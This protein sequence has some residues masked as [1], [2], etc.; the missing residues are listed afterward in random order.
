MRTFVI[1]AGILFSAGLS[2]CTAPIEKVSAQEGT[3][4]IG[5]PF[6]VVELFTSEGCTSCPKA[7]ALMPKMKEKYKDQVFILEYHVDYWD[8]NGWKDH[9]SDHSYSARQQDY[10]SF[11]NPNAVTIY[12][13]QA[14]V[15]GK[16]GINGSNR[17]SLERLIGKELKENS[18]RNIS[19]SVPKSNDNQITVAYNTNLGNSEVLHIALVQLKAE[20]DITSGENEGK[21]LPHDYIVRDIET[22]KR[23]KGELQLT[24]PDNLPASA[25]HIIGFVQHTV[26]YHITGA[27]EI[28]TDKKAVSEKSS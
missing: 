28:G 6:A 20:T 16:T 14:I 7:E 8:R 25:F 17:V 26:N 5:N 23:D 22:T 10:A 19:L 27:A 2:S 21:K 15:N 9:Y 12:T 18:G 4:T 3:Q 24:L 13:P 1:A 11:F